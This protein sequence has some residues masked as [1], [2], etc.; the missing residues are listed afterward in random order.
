[1]KW[2]YVFMLLATLVLR[3]VG[4]ADG[5]NQSPLSVSVTARK[6]TIVLGEPLLVTVNVKNVADREAMLRI[7]GDSPPR[8]S[9]VFVSQNGTDYRQHIASPF[10]SMREAR[11][12][13]AG[14]E[15]NEQHVVLY[16][17]ELKN[18]SFPRTGRFWIQA[19]CGY[20]PHGVTSSAPLEI[21]VVE[22]SG[23]D[24]IA[25]RKLPPIQEYGPFIQQQWEM[26]KQ[27]LTVLENLVQDEP[28]NVYSHYTARA[29]GNYYRNAY[30]QS[31]NR[32]IGSPELEIPRRKAM[33]YFAFA[34]KMTEVPAVREEAMVEW[35]Q[36]LD[37]Q[38]GAVVAEQALRE[39]PD[40]THKDY[41][42]RI[43]EKAHEE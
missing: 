22:P 18:L 6:T 16:D 36:M 8:A 21:N 25:Y 9:V 4:L 39:F 31:P 10:T 40:T 35:I 23:N 11:K 19:A 5:P 24:L 20:A 17:W 27:T 41:L 3:C 12:L 30:R 38:A 43:V 37:P 42:Q 2:L 34:A 7:Q 33:E 26:S 14:E 1:M 15:I 28:K 29:L 13:A 32:K